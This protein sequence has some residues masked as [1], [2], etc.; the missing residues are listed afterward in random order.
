VEVSDW[1]SCFFADQIHATY[2]SESRSARAIISAERSAHPT[3]FS[4]LVHPEPPAPGG[5][6]VPDRRS[7]AILIGKQM[8]RD[9]ECHQD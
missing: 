4:I 3:I 2:K 5:A 9:S 1:T 7:A 6:V 8:P